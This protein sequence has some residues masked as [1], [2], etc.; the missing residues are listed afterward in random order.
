MKIFI[1]GRPGS[2]KSTTLYKI[3]K[4]LKEKFKVGGIFTPEVRDGMKRI[5]FE[6]FDIF[7]GRRQ[8]FASVNFKSRLKVGKYFVDLEKFEEIAIP[9][10]EFAFESCDVV[11]I[12]EIGK[13]EFLSEN[14][15]VLLG[16]ILNSDKILVATLYI[17]YVKDFKNLGKL[18]FLERGQSDFLSMKISDEV[19]RFFERRL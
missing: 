5:G 19:I 3:V 14:F 16:K 6:V 12:D 4:N 18:Y 8:I 1:T 9:A 15:K 17:G 7:T 10:L 2:G 13:M 11:A